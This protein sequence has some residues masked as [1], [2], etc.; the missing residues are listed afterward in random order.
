M[1][2]EMQKKDS[3]HHFTPFSDN[4]ELPETGARVITSAHGIYI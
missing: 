2:S 3:N 4:K 1:F